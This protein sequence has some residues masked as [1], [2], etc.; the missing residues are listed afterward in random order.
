MK[1]LVLS[2]KPDSKV[3]EQGGI[4]TTD[5]L[6]F[7]CPPFDPVYLEPHTDAPESIKLLKHRLTNSDAVV[8]HILPG[9]KLTSLIAWGKLHG[10]SWS[11]LDA[12]TVIREDCDS[13]CEDEMNGRLAEVIDEGL[14]SD[15]DEEIA[16]TKVID[17]I[18]SQV[19]PVDA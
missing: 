1:I 11:H 19:A 18:V 5:A 6:P 15:E 12:A 16:L 10:S 8:V 4:D 2:D 9:Q 13:H 14:D 3:L 7:T 17:K